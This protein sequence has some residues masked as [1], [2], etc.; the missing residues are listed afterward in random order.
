MSYRWHLSLEK[1]KFKKIISNIS[2]ADSE[3]V[4]KKNCVKLNVC[5][6]FSG[7]I[8][9][10]QKIN[11]SGI[12]PLGRTNELKEKSRSVRHISSIS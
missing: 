9:T 10:I 5:C 4:K 12:F 7:L 3:K 2:K 8:F 6:S 11:W 1:V